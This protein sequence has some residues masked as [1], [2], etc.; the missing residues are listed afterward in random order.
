MASSL[1][2]R[3]SSNGMGGLIPQFKEFMKGMTPDG[4]RR[5]VEEL[6]KSGRMSQ[7]QFD[8]A[9]EQAT[10]FMRMFGGN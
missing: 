5:K 1:F 6:L 2:P 8:E 7:A 3:P 4:A 9:K 10:A